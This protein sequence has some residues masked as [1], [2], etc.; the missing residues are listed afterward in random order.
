MNH[1]P[2]ISEAE[3]EVMKVLWNDAPISTNEVT[4]KLTKT[5]SWNPKTIHTLLKRLVQKGAVTYR[6]E[7]RVFVYTPLVE[8][9]EYLK[10][11]NDHFLDRFYNG[12]ISGMVTSYINSDHISK[13]DLAELRRLLLGGQEEEL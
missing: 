2:Q 8:K 9:K 1:L 3:Y 12:K 4:D 7:G 10:K 13:E 6:K 5:T 11:E